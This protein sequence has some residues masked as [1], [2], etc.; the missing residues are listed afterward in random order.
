MQAEVRA[1]TLA[2]SQG[3][4]VG[5]VIVLVCVARIN[6]TV[7]VFNERGVARTHDIRAGE[8]KSKQ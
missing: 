1:A 3:R 6:V 8:L 2:L 7:F 4:A 5:A